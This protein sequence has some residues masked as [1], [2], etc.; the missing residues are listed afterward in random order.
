MRYPEQADL[1][2]CCLT[3]GQVPE[4]TDR[5][6]TLTVTGS[7][8]ESSLAFELTSSNATL[9]QEVSSFYRKR[10]WGSEIQNQRG[11]TPPLGVLTWKPEFTLTICLCRSNGMVSSWSP[12]YS[13][14]KVARVNTSPSRPLWSGVKWALSVSK[15]RWHVD[16]P[17][18]RSMPPGCTCH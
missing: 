7:F 6:A 1:L 3:K 10:N 13:L 15:S 14:Q 4:N 18:G 2:G 9:E 17:K 12:K 16:I 8:V 11:V 5:R